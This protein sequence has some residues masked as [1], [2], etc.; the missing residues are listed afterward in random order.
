MPLTTGE[1]PEWV[2]LAIDH[3]HENFFDPQ[4]LETLPLGLGVLWSAKWP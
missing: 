2:K 3:D 4:N 1:D